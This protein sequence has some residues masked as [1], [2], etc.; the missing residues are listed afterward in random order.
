MIPDLVKSLR[1]GTLP[2]KPD[3]FDQAAEAKV[4]ES[5]GESAPQIL[6]QTSLI[7]MFIT[8]YIREERFATMFLF[9]F[10]VL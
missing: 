3:A 5:L 6:I 7:V 9:I 10:Q 8:E 2:L 1:H 4:S